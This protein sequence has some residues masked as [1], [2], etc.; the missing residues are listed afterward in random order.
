MVL[1]EGGRAALKANF[2][3]Q[4]YF[5][6]QHFQGFADRFAGFHVENLALGARGTLH[7]GN[8]TVL[9]G[10]RSE[11][12]YKGLN[13]LDFRVAYALQMGGS[14][15]AFNFDLFNL[16]NVNTIT[17]I[18]TTSGS[19]FRSVNQFIPPR[20]ARFGVKLTF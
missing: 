13:I 1:Y 20:I 17:N 16:F 2:A 18:V 19:N 14:R 5:C 15:V 6:L 10:N 11:N 12:S 3:R 7:Q 4:L 9:S 8:I